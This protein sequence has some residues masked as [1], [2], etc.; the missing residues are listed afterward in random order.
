M[1]AISTKVVDMEV[2]M[3]NYFI[4][5]NKSY[6]TVWPAISPLYSSTKKLNHFRKCLLYLKLSI[7]KI[8][9]VLIYFSLD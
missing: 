7:S 9:T 6:F 2:F 3:L 5:Y 4:V 8:N 1:V